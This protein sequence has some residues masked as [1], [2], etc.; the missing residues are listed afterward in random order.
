M[1][2]KRISIQAQ[3]DGE[4]PMELG[5]VMYDVDRDEPTEVL[6]VLA[7]GFR[8]IAHILETGEEP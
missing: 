5:H 7:N 3:Y 6:K 8:T 4:E 2:E 1:S